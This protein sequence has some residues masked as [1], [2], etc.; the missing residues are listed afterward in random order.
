MKLR[1]ARGSRPVTKMTR[2]PLGRIDGKVASA[3]CER[4]RSTDLLIFMVATAVPLIGGALSTPDGQHVGIRGFEQF[5]LPTLCV[6]RWLGFECPTCGLTR[7]VVSLMAGD[8]NRSLAFHHFGWLIVLLILVQ[9]PYRLTRIALPDRR[10]PAL[11]RAG[12]AMAMITGALVILDWLARIV[13][14]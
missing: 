5:P 11:E 7:S 4:G 8:L 12:I 14:A 3:A 1:S 10:F 6:S 9:I 2:A 13:L